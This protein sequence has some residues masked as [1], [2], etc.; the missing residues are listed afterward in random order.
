MMTTT[1]AAIELLSSPALGED[2]WLA[3]DGVFGYRGKLSA[4]MSGSMDVKLA[5]DVPEM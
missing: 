2:K 5:S 1:P 4:T 3:I